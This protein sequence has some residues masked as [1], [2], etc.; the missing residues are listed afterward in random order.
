MTTKNFDVTQHPMIQKARQMEQDLRQTDPEKADKLKT[1]IDRKVQ[2]LEQ[3]R[4][5]EQT[6][7][8][9]Y[10]SHLIISVLALLLSIFAVI[11]N[12]LN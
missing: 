6:T 7:A 4:K 9:F 8:V 11:V 12:I 5:R 3:Q 10:L 1:D 2:A